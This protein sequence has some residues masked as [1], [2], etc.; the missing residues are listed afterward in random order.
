MHTKYVPCMHTSRRD[1]CIGPSHHFF[2]VFPSAHN[3]HL[4]AFFSD[5]K[6]THYTSI[7]YRFSDT[8]VIDLFPSYI[9]LQ[10]LHNVLHISIVDCMS[11]QKTTVAGPL[12]GKLPKT[13]A[14]I[15]QGRGEDHL[16]GTTAIYT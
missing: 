16:E 2:I 10:T 13:Q 14:I 3:S 4:N 12:H 8:D 5:D 15:R 6:N 9:L 11:F 7:S 1:D